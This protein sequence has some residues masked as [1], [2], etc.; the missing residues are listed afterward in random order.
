MQQIP[1]NQNKNTSDCQK[2]KKCKICH[3]EL[4]RCNEWTTEERFQQSEPMQWNGKQGLKR[5]TAKPLYRDWEERHSLQFIDRFYQTAFSSCSNPP[6]IFIQTLVF[7]E[8]KETRDRYKR[9]VKEVSRVVPNFFSSFPEC[10]G[11]RNKIGEK[12][13]RNIRTK[14][15][16]EWRCFSGRWVYFPQLGFPLLLLPGRDEPRLGLVLLLLCEG[17]T[18]HTPSFSVMAITLSAGI[19]P[20]VARAHTH[21]RTHL[22]YLSIFNTIS[23]S[24]ALLPWH[25]HSPSLSGSYT[26]WCFLWLQ[27]PSKSVQS[28]I[29]SHA[30]AAAVLSQLWRN[31]AWLKSC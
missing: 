1:K 29:N 11:D 5:L 13:R 27:I 14:E 10:D 15:E 9:S 20:P 8:T 16:P 18:V 3:Q 25:T 21:Y 17:K 6:P 30:S 24:P 31:S 7:V 28:K 2:K 23:P 4:E 22:H 19:F 12:L 26:C